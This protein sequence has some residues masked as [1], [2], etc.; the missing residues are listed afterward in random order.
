MPARKPALASLAPLLVV[1][2]A[3]IVALV[4][5]YDGRRVVQLSVL[6]LPGIA[7]LLIPVHSG[8]W[9]NLRLGAVWAWVMLFIVDGFARSYVSWNYDAAPTSSMVLSALANTGPR[10]S[11]EYLEMYAPMI[12]VWSVALLVTGLALA[13]AL[14]KTPV[15]DWRRIGRADWSARRRMLAALPIAILI[16]VA[17]ATPG[18]RKLHPVPYW[19]AWATQVNL[20]RSSLVNRIDAREDAVAHA[21]KLAPT[22]RDAGPSTVVLVLS[23]SIN[24]DNLGLYGYDRDTTPGLT[25]RDAVLG[26]DKLVIRNAWATQASTVAALRDIFFFGEETPEQPVHILAMAR[27]AG[28]RTWWISNHDDF[29]ISEMHAELADEQHMLSRQPGRITSSL[30]EIVLPSV[31]TALAHPAHRKLIVVHLLGGHPHYSY[32]YP[33]NQNPFLVTEDAT[34]ALLRASRRSK[35]VRHLREHYDGAML[36]HDRVLSE[37]LDATIKIP[38]PQGYRA[39]FFLS[40]HGQEVGHEVDRAGHSSITA[41][42][43]RIPAIFWQ[44]APRHSLGTTVENRPFRSDWT[45][46]TLMTL[47][48]IRWPGFDA[49]R[50]VLDPHYTWVAPNLAAPITSFVEAPSPPIR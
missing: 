1:C 21:K 7:L 28:Y 38:D 37:L 43:F 29:A 15:L 16:V 31:K 25:K 47:L 17:Y 32:R 9:H 13:I 46:W 48:G 12:A 11:R 18:W 49:T 35:W 19:T 36:Y 8:T 33:E 34:D 14:R 42:G 45:A 26:A 6:A 4:L 10:E 27:A 5:G 39:W 44:S 3:L 20:A 30:D 24:R 23:D 40:D 50:D 22:V 2:G 41:A